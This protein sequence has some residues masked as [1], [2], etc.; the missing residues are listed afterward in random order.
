ML[1]KQIF[2]AFIATTFASCVPARQYQDAVTARD[3]YLTEKTNLESTLKTKSEEIG[4][5]NET[6]E[7]QND[8]IN[9]L[10]KDKVDLQT[11]YNDM[12]KANAELRE[13]EDKLNNRINQ[14]LALSANETQN[15][16]ETLTAK[17]KEL[18]DREAEL[19]SKEKA[20]EIQQKDIEKL[21]AENIEKQK[22]I[23]E[24]ETA[25]ATLNAKI[26]EVATSLTKAL[27]GFSAADLTIE[28]KDGK[29][30]VKMSEKLLFASGSA[31]VDTKG[32]DA[33]RQI[34]DALKQ[35]QGIQ[36]LVEGHTDNVPLKSANYPKDNWD[37]SVLR[38]T[39]IVKLL[40]Q[41]YGLNAQAVSAAGRADNQP[42]AANADA[43]GRANNRRTEIIIVPNQKEILDLLQQLSK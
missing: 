28:Q 13:I 10:T 21:N 39:S 17:Q 42:V 19:K 36:I 33:L 5:L 32:K 43:T 11:R 7:E 1:K 27:S 12:L 8:T 40:T 4:R 22:R 24:L 34:A 35:Q 16:N 41:D 2:I 3:N 20:F 38:A 29:I 25:I 14:L 6:I 9:R 23:A 26:T 30:Y 15:L 31:I 37:L 18:S